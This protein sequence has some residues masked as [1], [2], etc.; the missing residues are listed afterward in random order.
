MATTPNSPFTATP[1]YV[2]RLRGSAEVPGPGDTD[3]SG[4]ANLDFTDDEVCYNVK[5]NSLDDA[6]TAMHIHRGP[7]GVAGPVVV[8]L[9]TPDT[10][11][12]SAGCADVDKALAAAIQANPEGYYVN[13]HTAKFPAGAARGQLKGHTGVALAAPPSGST[14]ATVYTF[15]TENPASATAART[16]ETNGAPIAAADFKPGTT[17]AYILLVT[18]PTQLTLVKSTL[19]GTVTVIGTVPVS[20]G[21]AAFGADFDPATGLLHVVSTADD[22]LTVNPDTAATTA[23][24][25]L[26]YAAGDPSPNPNPSISGIAYTNNFSGATTTGLFGVDDVQDTV[27]SI[28]P[29]TGT[30]STV[31]T[32]GTSP[33]NG[34][35]GIDVTSSFGLDIAKAPA[36]ELGTTLLA[37]QLTS[38][39]GSSLLALDRSTGRATN[40]G[41]LGSDS[42]IAVRAFSVLSL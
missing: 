19:A 25:T 32:T 37:G 28:D 7:A 31:G 3:A 14:L 16:F 1:D 21:G 2:V 9:K 41:Q 30:V 24:P 27:V 5:V 13:V 17:D 23:G 6:A 35:L 15:D 12:T 11:G 10:N 36:T 26:A 8:T 42:A 34:E 33:N 39:S 18:G 38:G 40:I 22:N 4:F 29:A 20:N